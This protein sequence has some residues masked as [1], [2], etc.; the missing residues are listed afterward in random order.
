M[1]LP[2]LAKIDGGNTWREQTTVGHQG[3]ESCSLEM[4]DKYGLRSL[5]DRERA[6]GEE[7]SEWSR[8][9]ATRSSHGAVEL[10]SDSMPL[11]RA[12][13]SFLWEVQEEEPGS[14][15]ECMMEGAG[16]F[17]GRAKA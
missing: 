10:D 13:A 15:E 17:L 1:S 5:S 3:M 8:R 9:K 7:L 12:F 6:Q 14:E 4:S 16:K 11:P 2:E